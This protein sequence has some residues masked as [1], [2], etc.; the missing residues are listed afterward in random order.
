MR[1]EEW[2]NNDKLGIDIWNK[3]YR[4]EN[5]SFDEWLNRVSNGNEKVKRLI[6][7]KKFLF[8]GRILANRGLQNK[9]RKIS[10]SN[11][12]VTTVDDSIED[13]FDAAKR[14]ARTYSYGGGIGLDLSNLSPRGATVHNAAK[15]S[16]GAVSFMDLYSTV[17]GLIGQ[18]GRRGALMLSMSC[19]H[20]D[21]EEFIDCKNDLSKVNFANISV[22][23]TDKFMKAVENDEEFKLSFTRKE[24]GEHIEKTVKAKDLFRKIAENNWKTGEPGILFWDRIENYNLLSE[25][26]DFHYASVNPC[27]EEPLPAGGSC[28]LG[29]LNLSEFVINPFTK[30]ARFD[31]ESFRNAVGIAVEA[32]NEVQHEGVSLHPLE[33][34]RDTAKKLKQIG[35]GVMGMA[36]ML[37]KLGIK[38]GSSEAATVFMMIGRAMSSTALLKSAD[39]AS[40]LNECFDGY[41]YD[42]ISK[43]KYFKNVVNIEE[44]IGFIRKNGLHNSQLLTIAP[45]GTLSTMLGISGGIE[46]IFANSY[47]RTTKTLDNKDTV[48]KVYTPIVKTFMNKFGIK[49]ESNLPDYFVTSKD[50]NYRDRINMQSVWQNY[51]DA[52]I[53]STVNV[54]NNFTVEQIMDMYMYA[55]KCGLK[56]VTLFREGCDRVAILNTSNSSATEKTKQQPQKKDEKELPR[57]FIKKIR[58]DVIGLERHL[59]TGCGSLHCQAFFDKKTG[60]LYETYLAK[61]SKGGCLSSLSGLSRMI[62]TSARAG[63]STKDIVDQLRSSIECPSYCVRRATKKDTS[64]GNCCPAAVGNALADMQKEINAMLGISNSSATENSLQQNEESSEYK[65]SETKHL[66]PECGEELTFEGGC[67]VCKSCGW[68]KCS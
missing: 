4:Y 25:Y 45:T 37:I 39:I 54:P 1:V 8:G 44:L 7:E 66:C 9:G 52:S 51:I 33:E 46:P 38:Y 50:I 48:Y 6:I 10:F 62:S 68:S 15:T 19:D 31:F 18:S 58:N 53:S 22:R 55:W 3:K 59:T 23:V 34:Q 2:L 14:I 32:L 35:L 67:V 63:V 12:Y 11:C 13:I 28:L 29:S 36:D 60:E 20:P 64:K 27:A 40:K 43:S 30:E 49:D 41:D 26:D 16:T 65:Y 56:G 21:I 42:L 47:E 61:G 5:E 24:T 57:G 17:T